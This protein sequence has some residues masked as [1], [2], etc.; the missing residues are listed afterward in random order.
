[1]AKSIWQLM[2]RKWI[3]NENGIY[4]NRDIENSESLRKLP[5]GDFQQ[6]SPS[7]L[8]MSF[9]RMFFS[10]DPHLAGVRPGA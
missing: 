5:R 4:S 3:T 10:S 2:Y 7:P 8:T 6:E 1:M 9:R